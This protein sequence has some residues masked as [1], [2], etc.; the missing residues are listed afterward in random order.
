M[1]LRHEPKPTITD[2]YTIAHG[3]FFYTRKEAADHANS[4][5]W[6]KNSARK[7]MLPFGRVRFV[8]SDPHM[9]IL[10]TSEPPVDDPE[11]VRMTI[12]H[13]REGR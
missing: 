1:E 9:N 11:D 8:V 2:T 13:L 5:G 12:E 6:P 3:L 7:V 10:M 4:I